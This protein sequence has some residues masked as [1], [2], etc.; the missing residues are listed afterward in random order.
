MSTTKYEPVLFSE[1]VDKVKTDEVVLPD[2]QRGFVWRDKNKQ[3]GLIASV[4]TRIPI[5]SILLLGAQ[6]NEF[7]YKK[8]GMKNKKPNIE[9]DKKVYALIDGQQRIT[10]LSAFLS[11]ELVVDGEENDVASATLLRRYFL[12]FYPIK[13]LL[14]SPEEDL[15]GAV[16]FEAAKEIVESS[17]PK[18]STDQIKDK[19]DFLDKSEHDI[20]SNVSNCDE[21]SLYTFCTT[22]TDDVMLLPLYYLYGSSTKKNTNH[23]NRF[24]GS[25]E[26][27]ASNYVDQ[28]I[29]ILKQLDGEK[30]IAIRLA[31]KLFAERDVLSNVLQDLENDSMLIRD[32]ESELY[33]NISGNLKLRASSWADDV[34]EYLESCIKNMELY[35]IIVEGSNIVRAIDIY[36]NLNLGGKALDV[37]DLL[38]ARAALDENN[39]NLLETV[40]DY[41]GTDHRA[42]YDNLCNMFTSDLAVI[43]YN[44]FVKEYGEY[45]ASNIMGAIDKEGQLNPTYCNILMSL[46][47]TLYGL[48]DNEGVIVNEKAE[49][50][51]SQCTKSEQ[52]LSIEV[53]KISK[54]IKQSLVGLD[55]ACFFL[56]LKCGIR[57]ISETKYRLLVVIIAV[58]LSQDKWYNNKKV[59]S[60]LDAWY[61]SILL[62]GGFRNEQNKVFQDNLRKI[63]PYLCKNADQIDDNKC[64]YIISL[65]NRTFCDN[66]YNTEDILLLNNKFIE[67]DSSISD[68]ICQ[69]YLS[70][71]YPDLLKDG[72]DNKYKQKTIGVFST[73]GEN[74]ITLHTHHIMPIGS[75]EARYR[76]AD[77]DQR[78]DSSSIYNS[79][80]NMVLISENSNRLIL[81][82][83]LEKYVNYCD[84]NSL[85]KVG[86]TSG[87]NQSFIREAGG[88]DVERVLESRFMAL[89]A[90]LK[91][92][93]AKSLG[94]Q[95]TE[96]ENF[97]EN[98]KKNSLNIQENQGK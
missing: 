78:N 35:E 28:S 34:R 47:G 63:L 5:G 3:K 59:I 70:L 26:A 93:Y 45:S 6:G 9:D 18:F 64:D 91:T 4:L 19:L 87:I 62:S 76:D 24:R 43:S 90:S 74:A 67:A 53:K 54:I 75:L 11:D 16:G 77:K 72:L 89:C 68:I 81:N 56:Q 2:F 55:R 52:L 40:K 83:S 15:F 20:L 85:N 14:V 60:M 37:F 8:I 32:E 69:Y 57:A 84:I 39:K 48:V 86:I 65:C 71:T 42:D 50:I 21:G 30:N 73:Y 22:H 79:P 17:Y 12:K 80:L 58:I 88:D 44:K 41:I 94:I 29:S 31:K 46:A 92:H 36:Q 33:K 38:L 23:R 61:W 51:T 96:I 7:K 27:I 97:Y 10:V 95:E 66:R 49:K 13:R 98:S 25:L 1:I 82:N